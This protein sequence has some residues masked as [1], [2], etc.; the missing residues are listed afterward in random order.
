MGQIIT[1][2]TEG[3]AERD[4]RLS[5]QQ[6]YVNG[7]ANAIDANSEA[8]F[9]KDEERNEGRSTLHFKVGMIRCPWQL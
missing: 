6:A 9:G 4:T 5:N 8:D 3:I 7:D 2:V 1:R